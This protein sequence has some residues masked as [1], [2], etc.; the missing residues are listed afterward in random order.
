ML[1]WIGEKWGRLTVLANYSGRR[2]YFECECGVVT[3]KDQ[4]NVRS[5]RTQSCGCLC[6]EVSAVTAVLHR[7]CDFNKLKKQH[8]RHGMTRTPTWRSWISMRHRAGKY[9]RYRLVSVDPEW[10]VS[11]KAFL[12]D[13]GLRPLGLTLDRYPDP[14]GDYEPTNCRWATYT[15]QQLNRRDDRR[16]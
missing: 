9:E 2:W 7:P 6:R 14:Y 13:M 10:Q 1:D 15:E 16:T 11:F 12:R 5:F 3:I 4:G 8:E